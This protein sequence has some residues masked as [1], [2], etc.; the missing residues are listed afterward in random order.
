MHKKIQDLQN[1]PL[2]RWLHQDNISVCFIPLYTP[3]LYSKY[4]VYKGM[5]YFL[6][7]LLLNIDCG[8]SLEPP[9]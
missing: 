3:L 4:G 8:Y 2:L 6:F 9:H 5:H 7:F 1:N